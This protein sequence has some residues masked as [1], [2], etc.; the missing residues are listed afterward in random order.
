MQRLDLLTS[1]LVS[2]LASLAV[3]S[4]CGGTPAVPQTTEAAPAAAPPVVR[5]KSYPVAVREG[6]GAMFTVTAEGGEPMKYQWQRDGVDIPGARGRFHI[7]AAAL[8]ADH[9]ARYAVRIS[10]AEGAVVV[11]VGEL[12]VVDQ[13]EAMPWL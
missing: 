12:I 9:A 6:R 11:E 8:R 2:A 4:A 1:L 7:V 10:N 13:A 3:L 5:T